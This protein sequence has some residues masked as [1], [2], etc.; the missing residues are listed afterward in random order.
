[1]A[2]IPFIKPLHQSLLGGQLKRQ[3]T[4][5]RPNSYQRG[6]DGRHRKWR[7]IILQR[8][9]V[10]KICNDAF[11]VVADHIT[12]VNKGGSWYELT[13]GQGLCES[14]HNRK[15]RMEQIENG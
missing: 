3:R 12:P 10:C 1:M 14:C 13:N 7:E 8:D 9:P 6:Y 5:N 11:S 2:G 4:D 15:S